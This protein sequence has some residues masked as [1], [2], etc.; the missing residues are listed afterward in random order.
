MTPSQWDWW[1]A[2]LKGERRDFDPTKVQSGYYRIRFG[3]NAP[4][5]YAPATARFE[6]VAIW[7]DESGLHVIVGGKDHSALDEAELSERF[8]ARCCNSPI[9]YEQYIAVADRGERWPDEP[10][11]TGHN[12]G[13]TPLET[14]QNELL[15]EKAEIDALLKAGPVTTKETADRLSNWTG[16]ISDIKKRADAERVTEKRPHDE[17]AAEV[18]A[19]WKPVIDET[20]ALLRRMK[21]AIGVFLKE[22][23]RVEAEARAK[24]AAEGQPVK[25]AANARAGSLGRKVALRTVKR[26]EITDVA[27][28]AAFIAALNTTPPEFLDAIQTIAGKM[29]RAG[30][31]VPGAKITETQVAA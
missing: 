11:V 19:R 3:T 28:A 25:A 16:R 12:L 20:D 10:A 5:R 21:D 6:P 23:A 1:G 17:A 13:I 8:F 27:A 4:S 15:G 18:Q 31:D 30:V 24:A 2:A 22:Q 26:V 29:L 7:R 14:I 9:S